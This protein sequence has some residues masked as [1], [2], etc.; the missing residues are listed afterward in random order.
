MLGSLTSTIADLSIHGR[1]VA[2]LLAVVYGA[3][4]VSN[5]LSLVDPPHREQ[6]VTLELV[7]PITCRSHLRRRGRVLSE[8]AK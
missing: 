1:T 3:M 2:L 7:L 6:G 5:P 4:G 8:F